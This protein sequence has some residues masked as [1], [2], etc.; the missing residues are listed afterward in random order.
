M[1]SKRK[2]S[3]LGLQRR[4]RPRRQDSPAPEPPV[5]PEASS[6]AESAP[7]E[8]VGRGGGDED[9]SELDDHRRHRSLSDSDQSDSDAPPKV[10][11]SA[12]SFGALARA[13]ESL[14]TS[15]RPKPAAQPPETLAPRTDEAR[16]QHRAPASATP[17]PKRS[18]KHAPQE[19]TSKRPVSRLREI[20][21]DT[22]RKPR[23]PRFDPLA[24]KLDETRTRKAYAFLDDYRDSEMADLRAQIKRAKNQPLVQEELKRQL[25]SMESR[26]KAR[27]R[28]DEEERLLAEHRRKEKELVAQGKTPFYLKKSEQKRQLLVGRYEKM[29]KRQVDRAME[30]KRKKVVGKERKELDGL[31]ARR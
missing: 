9:D 4:V 16:R 1:S 17:R 12:V 29:S 30:R 23:D 5:D 11:L 21:P 20:I 31:V 15:R 28:K 3:S 10:N 27:A 26:K 2:L 7:D 22:R 14:P 18:S 25:M 8:R 13:Q 19:Q 6:E 24:G